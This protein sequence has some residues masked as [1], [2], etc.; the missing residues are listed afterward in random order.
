MLHIPQYIAMVLLGVYS[1]TAATPLSCMH[2]R[3]SL[4]SLLPRCSLYNRAAAVV[5]VILLTLPLPI[6]SKFSYLGAFCSM[7]VVIEIRHALHAIIQLLYFC[8]YRSVSSNKRNNCQQLKFREFSL[9]S[10]YRG[11][12][13]LHLQQ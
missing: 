3:M 13:E 7:H 9:C 6:N 11:V 5:T 10:G 1:A 12:T 8:V 2:S 4:L